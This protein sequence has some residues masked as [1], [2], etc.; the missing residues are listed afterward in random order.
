MTVKSNL[1]GVISENI[2]HI[3]AT[4][5]PCS[6]ESVVG[7]CMVKHRGGFP[8]SEL[9]SPAK[10][11]RLILGV[12]LSSEEP[13]CPRDFGNGEWEQIVEP[14]ERLSQAYME[15]YVPTEGTLATQSEQWQRTRQVAALW[16]FHYHW[17]GLLASAEQVRDRIRSYFSP[18]DDELSDALGISATDAVEIA[19]WF[20][21]QM[22]NQLD[23]LFRLHGTKQTALATE[24]K[25]S[26][27]DS[28]DLESCTPDLPDSAIEWA[29][30]TR[31]MGKLCLKTLVERYG[32]AGQAFWDLF[33]VKRG[34]G[35]DIEYPTARSIVETMPLIQ[36]SD[37]VAMLFDANILLSA[38]LT[39]A[40]E[41]LATGHVKAKFFRS[42][43]E[44]LEDQTASAL[45]R[46]LGSQAKLYRNVFETRDNQREHD[47]VILTEDIC[48]FVEAKASPPNEPFRDPEK[49][50]TRLKRS[51]RSAS[52][53]Q[54]AYEQSHSLL[55]AVRKGPLSLY[56]KRGTEILCLPSTV[57]DSKFCVCVTNDSFG[58]LATFLSMLLTKR[59][60]DPY[61]WAVNILDLQQIVDVWEYFRWGGRQL[62]SFL[63]QRI[64]LHDNVFSDHEMDYVAAYVNHCGLHHFA[65]SEYDWLQLDPTYASTFNGI[66]FHRYHG[67][68]P[69]KFNPS[70]PTA[71]DLRQSLEAGKPIAPANLLEG[72]MIV[73]RNERCPCDSGVKFKSCH[74]RWIGKV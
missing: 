28:I 65:Q 55:R 23:E 37:G 34:Q 7:Y 10:Q 25:L 69:V 72:P 29:Q 43:N 4:L 67:Q 68:P 9:S 38:I 52:G 50:F 39:R 44:T 54:G 24:L 62:K 20:C 63:S 60:E 16:F 59:S 14:L 17:N 70:Y 15:L 8:N 11:I 73:G 1:Q 12:M 53:I 47:I 27:T 49:A 31:R 35:P 41:C 33:T 30:A 22:Q 5:Q 61:P 56:D 32:L 18:F 74:G 66:Y 19:W 51:F 21:G 3:R 64:L 42:R 58:P 45:H 46:I 6:T 13:S 40:E 57:S 71:R 26:H 36:I 48:L 2:A